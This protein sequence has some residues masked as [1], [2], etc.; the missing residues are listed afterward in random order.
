MP[1]MPY[2]LAFTKSFLCINW[3]FRYRDRV[4]SNLIRLIKIP[5]L[6]DFI[7]KFLDSYW[8]RSGNSSIYDPKLNICS[9]LVCFA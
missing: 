7:E 3:I 1:S 2:Q 5:V 9:R 4:P 8:L 6:K